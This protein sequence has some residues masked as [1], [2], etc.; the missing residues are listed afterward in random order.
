MKP[1]KQNLPFFITLLIL[2][3][4][5]YVLDCWSISNNDDYVYACVIGPGG[6]PL[7]HIT[8]LSQ[9]F[10]SLH[11]HYYTWNGRLFIHFFVH[12]FC[13]IGGLGLF[14]I[15][16]TLVFVLFLYLLLTLVNSQRK[17]NTF[18]LLLFTLFIFSISPIFASMF[19]GTVAY[20]VNYL[21]VSVGT[22]F[23]FH[24]Y[25]KYK[26]SYTRSIFKNIAI[27]LSG[28]LIGSMHEGFSIRLLGAIGLYY[29]FHLKELNR[30]LVFLFTGFA[31]GTVSMALAPANFG[32]ANSSSVYDIISASFHAVLNLRI[33]YALLI[34]NIFL[35]FKNRQAFK[36]LFAEN[37]IYYFALALSFLFII[38]IARTGDSRPL[39][40]PE[41][42][43]L[44]ILLKGL[45]KYIDDIMQRCHNERV[46][47]KWGICICSI[48]ILSGFICAFTLRKETYYLHQEFINSYIS[49]TDG[50]AYADCRLINSKNQRFSPS[51]NDYVVG[52]VW[53]L[54]DIFP[55][56]YTG[57]KKPL[58]ALPKELQDANRFFVKDNQSSLNPLIYTTNDL[59]CYI[60]NIKDIKNATPSSEITLLET[61]TSS[62]FM[63]AASRLEKHLH[64]V[65]KTS[66]SYDYLLIEKNNLFSLSRIDILIDGKIV[67]ND[68]IVERNH[69]QAKR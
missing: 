10:E 3:I 8:H 54:N 66:S 42:F 15:C 57:R 50:T 49:S 67:T 9:I 22:L 14:R 32:R 25:E 21:W 23:F 39:Y 38:F 6:Y 53:W 33:I 11:N 26:R 43:A 35:Y 20:S 28:I 45:S 2:G 44:L 60:I 7:G 48:C 65:R 5:F 47:E 68:D 24:F 61:P 34:F 51:T 29:I 30:T 59:Y 36:V 12:F 69:S 13:S 1:S 41:F 16:N 17:N 62:L 56:Y 37:K 27:G 46:I 52:D 31:I 19:L 55:N 40:G 63:K 18:K 4:A 64:F 58:I